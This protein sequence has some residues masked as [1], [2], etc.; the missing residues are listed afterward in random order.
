MESIKMETM[1]EEE[2]EG[3]LSR[4]DESGMKMMDPCLSSTQFQMN[5]IMPNAFTLM[6]EEDVELNMV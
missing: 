6:E 1:E 3:D 2:E 4:L 5:G